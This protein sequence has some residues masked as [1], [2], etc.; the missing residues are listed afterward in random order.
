MYAQKGYLNLAWYLNY[1]S[2]IQV[3]SVYVLSKMHVD[4]ILNNTLILLK[5]KFYTALN[6]LTILQQ[7]SCNN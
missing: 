1:L 4:I 7:L 2:L 6:S 5:D 3:K